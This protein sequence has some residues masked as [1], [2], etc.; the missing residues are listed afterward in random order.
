L[1]VDE[2]EIDHRKIKIQAQLQKAGVDELFIVQPV[3]MFYSNIE[4]LALGAR[5]QFSGF[6]I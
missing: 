5:L 2:S 6:T 4:N 1:K 3:D